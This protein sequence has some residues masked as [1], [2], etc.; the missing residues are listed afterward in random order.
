MKVSCIILAYNE[1]DRIGTALTHALKWADE[2]VV[3]DKCSHDGTCTAAHELGAR[4][5]SIPFTRQ[6]FENLAE[7]HALGRNEWTW[8]FTPGEVPTRKA[9][10]T[11]LAM[12]SDDVDLITVPMRYYSFGVHSPSSPWGISGH[13]RLLRR[14]RV[15]F[16]GIA[17]DPVR[18]TRVQ[19]IPYGPDSFVLHQTHADAQSFV[20]AHADYMAGEA[21]NGTPQDV[22]ARAMGEISRWDSVWASDQS[23]TDQMMGWK[24]YWLGVAMHARDRITGGHKAE[25]HLR[26]ADM[27]AAEGWV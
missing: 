8:L 15:E 21:M 24:L 6:G 9:I 22:I 4:V 14:S 26:A 1:I 27:L 13:P 7:V 2:V 19:S 23:L 3:A 20:R 25:Y 17:H 5:E 16:T 12:V 18:A 11:G 10:E